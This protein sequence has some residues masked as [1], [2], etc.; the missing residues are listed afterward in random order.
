MRAHSINELEALRIRA[1]RNVRRV[2]RP[3]AVARAFG[4]SS[5]RTMYGWLARY[6]RGG[7]GFEG[8]DLMSAGHAEVDMR[9]RCNG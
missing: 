5:A 6:R 7:C 9:A 1:V 4:R 8:Q 3:S 2:E